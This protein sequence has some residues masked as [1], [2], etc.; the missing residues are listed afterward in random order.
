MRIVPSKL[1]NRRTI[2]SQHGRVS[3]HG[4]A[5]MMKRMSDTLK[6]D[7]FP[8]CSGC[9]L[10]GTPIDVQ[11]RDKLDAVRSLFSDAGLP[12]FDAN[13]I[14]KIT[15]SPK[16][17]AYRN[18]VRLAVADQ[19]KPGERSPSH[20]ALGLY[21]A[22]THDIVD[23]PHCPVQ[24][25][26]INETVEGIRESLRTYGVTLYDERA[27]TGDLRYVSVRMGI[28]TGEILVGLV[29]SRS[30]L[31]Q[32]EN[33]ASRLMRRNPHTVGVVLN[34]NP[35]RGNV[36]FGETCETLAGRSYL[37]ET[38]CGIRIHLG[39]QSFFQINT[40]IAE[41]AYSAIV[42]H[43]TDAAEHDRARL[44]LLDLFCG[45]GTIGLV[46]ARR[47]ARVI[48]VERDAE[49]I[50][51]AK[52]AARINHL[53]NVAFA[54]GD[55][56]RELTAI[57]AQHAHRAGSTDRLAVVVNPPRKGLTPETRDQLIAIAP[58]RFAYLSC[59]PQTLLRDLATLTRERFTLRHVELFDM[60]PQTDQVETLAILDR[61]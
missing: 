16:A 35:D 36:I 27:H 30:E 4:R 54:A 29:A 49:A 51:H 50:G 57:A 31:P 19:N 15:S 43:L 5:A 61:R 21:R 8:A 58:D 10:I 38:V 14:T 42:H 44:T 11:L 12:R 32:K 40:G 41:L 33:L 52:D 7:H 22:G 17:Y 23:I 3:R 45:V 34:I 25:Q 26:S 39:L 24:P 60:F 46:A 48:G 59:A 18:R 37:E 28:N 53:D 9:A 13:A 20:I 56:A 55:V 47:V 2:V 6:C 1:I